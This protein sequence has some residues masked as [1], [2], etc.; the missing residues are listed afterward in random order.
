MTYEG[1]HQNKLVS[2]KEHLKKTFQ[3]R[4]Q[5]LLECKSS[6]PP[7]PE[8]AEVLL[9]HFIYSA[10]ENS[11]CLWIVSCPINRK[12]TAKP[13]G[14]ARIWMRRKSIFNTVKR[15]NGEQE[16]TSTNQITWSQLPTLTSSGSISLNSM[17]RPVQAMKW[18]LA[19][20]SRRVTRNCHSW[21]EPRLW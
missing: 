19:G 3:Q 10:A 2:L 15:L 14:Q 6:W 12:G 1:W 20:S 17:P 8:F 4:E 21:R 11:A 5:T 13:I 9:I 7:S 18:A 16:Q